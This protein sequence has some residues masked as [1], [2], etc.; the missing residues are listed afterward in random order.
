[1]EK[2]IAAC[3]LDCAACKAHIATRTND[4]ALREATAKEWSVAHNFPFTPEMINCHGCFATDGVQIGHCSQCEWRA[5]VVG[6]GYK[7]C[8]ECT[9]MT[10]CAKKADFYQHCPEA[11]A[12]LQALKRGA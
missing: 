9:E 5:C 1:M 10:S 11:L 8:A 2:I 4:Q 6:K 3:G 7:S 12:N